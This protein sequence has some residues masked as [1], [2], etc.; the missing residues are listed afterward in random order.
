MILCQFW[1]DGTMWSVLSKHS[2]R[3]RQSLT[4]RPFQGSLNQPPLK[5]EGDRR[6]AVEGF[7]W[8]LL[9]YVLG[10]TEEIPQS[11]YGCQLP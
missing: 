7:L 10:F 2:I 1:F 8:N 3:L 4:S 5:G 9:L 6:Q 11:A